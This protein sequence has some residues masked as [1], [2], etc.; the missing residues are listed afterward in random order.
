MADAT[1]KQANAQN[2]LLDR[3][4][5]QEFVRFLKF[6]TVGGSGVVVNMGVLWIATVYVFGSLPHTTAVAWAGFLAIAISI[7]TNFLLNDMWTWGDRRG[8]GASPFA[9][10]LGKYVL[11]ASIAGVVQWV[12]LQGLVH[13]SVHYMLANF[14]GIAAGIAINYVA[15]NWW[16]FRSSESAQP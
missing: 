11:V 16:T 4:R 9:V 1:A 6:A 8:T 3:V 12:I 7:L 13:V 14:V 10:R 5:S 15:N 2:G